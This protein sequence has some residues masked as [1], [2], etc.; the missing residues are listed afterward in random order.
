M[1]GT[2]GD[3]AERLSAAL[4]VTGSIPTQKKYLC[5]LLQVVVSGLGVSDPRHRTN[6]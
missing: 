6:S 2:V 3:V 5:E 4:H 1:D